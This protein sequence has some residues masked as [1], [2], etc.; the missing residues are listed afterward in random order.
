[1]KAG[2]VG[3]GIAGLTCARRLLEGG[4]AVRVLDKARGP[5]GRASTRRANGLRFDHGAQ[6][7]TVRTSGFRKTVREMIDAGSVAL[8]EGRIVKLDGGSVQET[9]QRKRFVGVPGMSAVAGFLAEGVDV[10]QQATVEEISRQESGWRLRTQEGHEEDCDVVILAV[11]APQALALLPARSSLRDPVARVEMSPCLAAMASFPEPLRLGY[12]AAFVHG[13]PLSW[14]ARNAGKPGRGDEECWV[15]HAGPEFSAHEFGEDPGAVAS[16]LIEEMAISVGRSLP[17][18]GFLAS[19]RWRFAR[20]PSPLDAGFLYDDS[21]RMGVCGDWC[22][23]DRIEG[24]FLSGLAMA[25]L[26][27]GAPPGR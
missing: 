15:L 14:I 9:R 22:A 18:P 5:G 25:S 24:A 17:E 12:E 19:H 26:V 13:S 3:A 4:A 8:W 11:P 21:L 6:Y 16:R 27:L 23:G 20:T 7:L 2:I 1:M 10:T